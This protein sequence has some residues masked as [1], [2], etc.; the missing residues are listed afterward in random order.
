MAGALVAVDVIDIAEEP[1]PPHALRASKLIN[2][3]RE[4]VNFRVASHSPHLSTTTLVI[5][6]LGINMYIVDKC[7]RYANHH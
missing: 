3:V 7:G 2:K 6:R 1:P 4:I 5:S